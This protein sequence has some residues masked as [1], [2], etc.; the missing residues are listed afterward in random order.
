MQQ[1]AEKGVKAINIIT[2]GFGEMGG[3]EGQ[4]RHQMMT[5][6]VKRTGIRIVGPNCF[7]N[8][9]SPHHFAGMP[10][11]DIA[12]MR[13]GR[14]SL[15]FQS[16]GLAIGVVSACVDRYIG[17]AHVISSGNEVDIEV[18]DCV[19]FFAEDEHTQV[20]GCYVEQFH[21][22]QK[23]LAA[24]E[25]CAERQKPIVV[26][27]VGRSE[28]GKRMA[29]AHTGSL[30]GSDT[31]I[32]A[33]LKKYGIL[34]VNDL[35]E[36]LET[37]VM[38]HSRKLPRGRGVAVLTASGGANAVL[39]DLA[40]DIGVEL[41]QFVGEGWQKVRS[42][43][44]DY[45]TVSNPLDITGPGGVTDQHVHQAAVEAMGADPNMHI[46]LHSLG[47]NAKM[48]AQSPAGKVLLAAMQKYPD[49]IWAK[50][51]PIAG[52]F[53]E[54]PLGVAEVIA[55]ITELE[56]IPFLQGLD[57]SLRA[58]AALIRYAEFQQKRTHQHLHPPCYPP[59]TP[60]ARV[61][62]RDLLQA[63]KG[64][65]LTETTGKE[66]L[67]LYGI[68]TTKEHI[69]TTAEAAARAA[70]EIGFPV[71]MKII[72]P[73]I[74]HK[75]EAG[76]VLLSVRS[77]KEAREGFKHIMENARQYNAQ[78]ELHGVSVQEMVSGGR[79]M[80]VGMTHDPQFGPAILLGLGG[81]FV[82]V[83][84]DVV[85]R[86]PP[87]SVEDAQEM[88]ESL[89]GKAMLQGARGAKPAD[90]SALV[91]VLQKFSQLCLDLRDAISEIDI[92]PLV[93]LAEGQGVKA[94]DCLVV[95]N[96]QGQS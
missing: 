14:L 64:Q 96:T 83:L 1:C 68:P 9:S 81:I 88:I 53:H 6:F 21:N 80:I 31:V 11:T 3:E 12:A 74:M 79:E 10:R 19:Q 2:S 48:D 36:M 76:G 95:P 84:R 13:P 26:L 38:L 25:V 32:D 50:M 22:P 82:E 94:L 66:L 52:N 86:T 39:T 51:A 72:S 70:K 41:P 92:N 60:Q 15:A 44:Y 40:E 28:A 73:Q 33:V 30:A 23:F 55:P 27:K 69:A 5:D 63:A 59:I 43:L 16:G 93:V 85:V 42:A 4:R 20:I 67:A 75:T 57:N 49:K 91:G 37:M 65:A 78:A 56:G 77:V 54:K 89:R 8:M 24:A 7:G 87:L 61:R 90:L 62:A 35:N 58:V 71:A 17:L 45:I 18:G 34:R 46:I 47:G 29:Q